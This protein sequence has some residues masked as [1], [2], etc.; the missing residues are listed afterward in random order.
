MRI[1][2]IAAHFILGDPHSWMSLRTVTI[3]ISALWRDARG[4]GLRV[5]AVRNEGEL[6]PASGQQ[7]IWRARRDP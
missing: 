4:L 6:K 3:S 5:G 7:I 2:T 1:A